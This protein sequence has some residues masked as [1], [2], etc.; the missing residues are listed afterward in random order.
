MSRPSNYPPES[1]E[2]AGELLR[3]AG[4]ATAE[5][6]SDVPSTTRPWVTRVEADRG[7][8]GEPHSSGLLP[9]TAEERAELS[10]LR[11]ENAKLTAE[12]EL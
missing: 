10:P 1:R 3:A 9:L 6:A 11:R 5:V 4:K 7:Q 2:Q 12:R 8:R